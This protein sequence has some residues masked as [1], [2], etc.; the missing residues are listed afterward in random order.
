[1]PMV[2]AMQALCVFGITRSIAAT[3]GSVFYSVGRP[4]IQ[5]KLAIVQLII[6]AV[7]I[8]PLTVRWGILGTS[9][10]V[11]IPMM[12]I[13]ILG[14]KEI[15]NILASTYRTFFRTIGMMITALFLMLLVISLTK[16]FLP[17]KNTA[18]FILLT[19]L[20]GIIYFG[21]IYLWDRVSG[22][23]MKGM[24]KDILKV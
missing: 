13:L 9:L 15:K 20:G 22:Y 24:I 3:M 7:I 4:K 17:E 5:T 12:V 10:A 21:S 16:K 23:K 6:M 11:V 2:P 18:N 8:Y 1:M 14:T 19:F